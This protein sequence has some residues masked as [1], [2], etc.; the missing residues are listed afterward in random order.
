MYYR[1]GLLEEVFD[2]GHKD[3]VT[4]W[5]QLYPSEDFIENNIYG[6]SESPDLH[7][8]ALLIKQDM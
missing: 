7:T 4:Q 1:K 5:P 3:Q 8:S 2:T 6:Y